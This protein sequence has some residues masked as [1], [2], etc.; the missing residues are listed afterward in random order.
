MVRSMKNIEELKD[1]LKKLVLASPEIKIDVKKELDR[2]EVEYIEK[3]IEIMEE[4]EYPETDIA[5][6]EQN[7]KEPELREYLLKVAEQVILF[8][9]L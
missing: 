2:I 8:H 9:S 5:Y 7:K 4:E 6:L 1:E 3:A